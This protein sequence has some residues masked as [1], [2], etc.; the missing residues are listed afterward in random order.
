MGS[1]FRSATE[2]LHNGKAPF[3]SWPRPRV[4]VR[5]SLGAAQPAFALDEVE[6]H[7]AV[8]ELERTVVSPGGV[9]GLAMEVFLQSGKDPLVIVEESLCH[10]FD[11][12]GFVVTLLNLQRRYPE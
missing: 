11:I 8:E 1:A 9:A 5:V 7:Q 2:S 4:P 6:E 12:K 10:G 3:A